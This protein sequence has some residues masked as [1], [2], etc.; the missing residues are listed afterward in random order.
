MNDRNTGERG[1]ANHG[2]LLTDVIFILY[3]YIFISSTV[4]QSIIIIRTRY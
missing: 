3:F 1:V 2:I 4:V